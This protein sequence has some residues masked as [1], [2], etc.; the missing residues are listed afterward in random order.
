MAVSVERVTPEAVV[1][2]APLAPNINHRETAFGGSLSALAILT[3]WSLLH[4]RLRAAGIA[5]RLVI[6]R[7]AMDY[8]CPALGAF[9]ARAALAQAQDW[10]PFLRLLARRGRARIAVTSVL[11]EGG[12]VVGRFTGE[13]VALGAG[14]APDAAPAAAEPAA[15]DGA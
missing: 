9:T 6:Q 13:F 5:T 2:A 12:R 1:L 3:A 11:H 15:A 14:G 8:E 7:H 10:P 4:T